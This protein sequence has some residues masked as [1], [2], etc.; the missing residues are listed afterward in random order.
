MV[1]S[2]V[3]GSN[4]T[5]LRHLFLK[6]QKKPK[7]RIYVWYITWSNNTRRTRSGN[8]KKEPRSFK[9]FI[10]QTVPLVYLRLACSW[11]ASYRAV[12]GHGTAQQPLNP[13][14]TNSSVRQRGRVAVMSSSL[15]SKTQ[16]VGSAE[17]HHGT[18]GLICGVHRPRRLVFSSLY[19]AKLCLCCR[20]YSAFYMLFLLCAAP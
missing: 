16:Q 18:C 4:Y 13:L 10:C 7:T 11:R 12:W 5:V 14:A 20:L 15:Q 8:A 19:T 3:H 17:M 2:H 6:K 1:N 9:K